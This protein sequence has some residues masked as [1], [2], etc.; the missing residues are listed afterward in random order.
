M[1][2]QQ[3]CSSRAVTRLCHFTQSR[4]LAHILGDCTGILS[5]S[6]LVSADLP[7][8]PTDS[9]RYDGCD[10]LVCCSLEY[11]NAYYFAKVR[12]QDH[13]FKDWVVLLISP[14]FIWT[15]GTKFCP[16]NAAT[17]H[18]KYIGEG[19]K[20]F[21]SLFSSPSA[22]RGVNRSNTHLVC[23]P[24]DIQAEV[25][26]PDPI[27]LDAITAIAVESEGQAEREICRAKLQGLSIDKPIIVVPDFYNKDKLAG[28]IR[29]GNRVPEG[30]YNIGGHHGQ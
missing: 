20:A 25:L 17:A 15:P 9:D 26:V 30:I 11:P 27:S 24:T 10:D 23:S 12:E 2:I 22:G 8:N 28:A 19:Y 3:E 14:I 29:S 1:K 13:L 7:H 6:A 18:G 5:R 16:C 4:N 21:S